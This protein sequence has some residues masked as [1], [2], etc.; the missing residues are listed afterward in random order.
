MATELELRQWQADAVP[1]LSSLRR[2]AMQAVAAPKSTRESDEK[3]I[4]VITIIDRLLDGAKTGEV[5]T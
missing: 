1:L 2:I 5:S 4:A 3:A